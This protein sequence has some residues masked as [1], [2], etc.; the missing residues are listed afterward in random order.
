MPDKA[1]QLLRDHVS[2]LSGHVLDLACGFGRNGLF[3]LEQGCEVTF[4]ERNELALQDVAS[5]VGGQAGHFWQV[6]LEVPDSQPLMDKSYDGVLVFRYLH[7]PLMSALLNAIQPGGVL[8]YETFTEQQAEVGRPTNPDFLLK[9]G[10]LASYV[11]GWDIKH[12]FEGQDTE[13]GSYIAQI[14]AVKPV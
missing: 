2:L 6:D 10:E 12:S 7:R 11:D 14:V 8:V 3:C 4:A 1:S 9:S 13:T 5:K